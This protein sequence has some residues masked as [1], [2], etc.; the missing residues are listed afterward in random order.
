MQRV[1]TTHQF[2]PAATEHRVVAG[3]VDDTVGWDSVVV[4]VRGAGDAYNI[5]PTYMYFSCTGCMGQFLVEEAL[6]LVD[7]WTYHRGRC[8]REF[9]PG[10]HE[11]RRGRQ[12]AVQVI[13]TFRRK[14]MEEHGSPPNPLKLE[15]FVNPPTGKHKKKPKGL[16][17]FRAAVT[18]D[19]PKLL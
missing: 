12:L 1:P 19:Q 9:A 18:D 5:P 16:P 7:Q 14:Y 2:L 13:E 17:K 15:N 10:S 8:E 4:Y 3:K 11:F 6:Y